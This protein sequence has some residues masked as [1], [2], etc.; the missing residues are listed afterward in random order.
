MRSSLQSTNA[1][2]RIHGSPTVIALLFES[3]PATSARSERGVLRNVVEVQTLI[4]LLEKHG[5]LEGPL[6][7]FFRL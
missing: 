3:D 4:P 1:D 6:R 7:Y 5:F 2:V